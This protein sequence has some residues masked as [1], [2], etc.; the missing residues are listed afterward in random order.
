MTTPEAN[1]IE[2]LQLQL[3]LVKEM[4]C[5]EITFLE[6]LLNGANTR[7]YEKIEDCSDAETIIISKKFIE[8]YKE[9]GKLETILNYSALAAVPIN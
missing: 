8:I 9:K 7:R 2:G 1:S 4:L 6:I 3:E 5:D